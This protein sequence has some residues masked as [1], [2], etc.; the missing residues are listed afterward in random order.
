M[1]SSC[2]HNV[3]FLLLALT[4][5][6]NSPRMIDISPPDRTTG[7]ANDAARRTYSGQRKFN[8]EGETR[9]EVFIVGA[10]ELSQCRAVLTT[11][12]TWFIS[13]S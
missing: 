12:Q 10:N 1:L 6:L 7:P 3:V 11:K 4:A 5:L 13:K 8:R 2:V 9:L